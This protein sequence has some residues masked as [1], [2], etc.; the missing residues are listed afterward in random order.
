MLGS[1]TGTEDESY[2]DSEA[3]HDR[4]LR[5]LSGDMDIVFMEGENTKEESN[6]PL[7]LHINGV[8]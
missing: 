2:S 3:G 7:E 8:I 6:L 4:W 5:S 1:Q